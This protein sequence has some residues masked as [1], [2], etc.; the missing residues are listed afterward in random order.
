MA[1]FINRVTNSFSEHTISDFLKEM[2][3]F[4]VSQ[5]LEIL[6][7][8]KSVGYTESEVQQFFN[9]DLDE[10]EYLNVISN[11]STK[12]TPFKDAGYAANRN[13]FR[14]ISKEGEIEDILTILTD[15]SIVYDDSNFFC[16]VSSLSQNLRN[17]EDLQQQLET[18]FKKIY[19]LFN[20]NDTTTAWWL[21]YKFLVD[22]FLCFEIV[23][24]AEQTN[25]IGF[26][27]IDPTSLEYIPT[28][29]TELNWVQYR[30]DAMRQRIL[31]ESQIIYISYASNLIDSN[32]SYVARLIKPY[33]L[34]QTMEQTRTTWAV[35]NSSFRL[36][37]I[38]PMNGKSKNQ[39]KQTLRMLMN[40]YNEEL[41]YDT[42]TGEY[43]VNGKPHL[44]G[45]K[46]IW[47]PEKDGSSPTIETIGGDGPDLSDTEALSYFKNKL[48]RMSKIP[49]SRFN[50]SDYMSVENT[51]GQITQ[52]ELRFNRFII[53]LRSVFKELLVKPLWIQMVLDN[54]SLKNDVKFKSMVNIEYNQYNVFEEM[55]EME[56]ESTKID[57]IQKMMELEDSEGNQYIPMNILLRRYGLFTEEELRD[58]EN[59]KKQKSVKDDND[60][61]INSDDTFDI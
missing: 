32:V 27:E 6:K 53:R 36:K 34:L 15:E 55:K 33:N 19:H 37:F 42:S 30:G 8:S 20:F 11:S 57:H 25:I 1:G 26:K 5:K 46:Q 16:G 12:Y 61:N 49:S 7:N 43:H 38:I 2:G 50:D 41:S 51:M 9:Y 28:S 39:S 4:G 44:P 47:L 40:R 10:Y 23:Y 14:D 24:N 45:V 54:P 17:R 18:N 22:G 13:K 21:F 31:D 56:I 29:D 52:E 48:Q 60:D 58:I 3:T 35:V 59:Y